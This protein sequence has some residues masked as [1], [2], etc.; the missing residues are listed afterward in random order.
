MTSFIDTNADAKVVRWFHLFEL[1]LPG[2]TVLRW[3]DDQMPIIYGGH[4]YVPSIVKADS[5]STQQGTMQTGVLTVGNADNV[6]GAYLFA[7]DLTG[8][9]VRVWQ[10][11]LDPATPGQVP[12]E[13]RAIYTG[14]V[15][16][17]SLTRTGQNA[18]VKLTLGPYSDPSTK[19]LPQRL[20]ANLLVH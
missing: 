8:S 10:A 16:M 12:Q 11:W 4:T 18:E 9:V 5:I 3:C 6:F 20:V 15:A 19:L 17:A 13:V 1:D 2:P 7:G 14:R